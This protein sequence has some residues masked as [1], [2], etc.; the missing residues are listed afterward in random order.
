MAESMAVPGVAVQPKQAEAAPAAAAEPTPAR[1]QWYRN[2]QI[3]LFTTGAVLMP[4]GIFAIF[5]GWYGV[6]HTKYQYDQLPYV[7]SGGL[8]GL[9]LVFI[10]G[11]LYFGAWLQ[12]IGN[13]QRETAR[14]LADSMQ[15][16]A[17]IVAGQ[18]GAGGVATAGAS[19]AVVDDTLVLAGSGSTIHRRDCPLIA[20]RDDLRPVNGD[21]ENFGTCRVCRPNVE[22]G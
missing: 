13:D 14:K 1:E 7:V 5:L 11:F 8:L 10:G 18:S 6:A 22:N 19:E 21:S 17:E 15:L 3:I 2:L 16:L 12:R 9:A 4:A 20:H